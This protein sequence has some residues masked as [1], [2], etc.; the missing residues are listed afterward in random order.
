M[1]VI[2]ASLEV[3]PEPYKSMATTLADV[4]AYAGKVKYHSH[5]LIFFWNTALNKS[6]G[7][8]KCI[9]TFTGTG[10]V[11]KVQHLL[12]ICSEHYDAKEKES[13]S[14]DKK[15]D[16][17][18][19]KKDKDKKDKDKDKDKDKKEDKKEEKKD[20]EEETHDLSSQQGTHVG[21]DWAVSISQI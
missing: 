9:V 16:K 7:V 15:E 17:S 5:L 8:S 1:E 4:C 10:N 2:L 12:H 11:L 6:N 19:E 20:A 21:L 3:I 18:K 13:S 14:K